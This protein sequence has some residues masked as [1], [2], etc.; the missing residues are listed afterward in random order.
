MSDPQN[1]LIIRLS[2]LGDIILASPLIRILRSKYPAAQIDLLVKPQYAEV[3]RSNPHLS[4]II[5]LSG[6]LAPLGARL[7]A[8]RYDLLID[9]HNSLRSRY[10]RWRAHPRAVR[11]VNKYALRRFLLVHFKWNLYRGVIPVAERYLAAGGNLLNDGLGLEVFLPDQV[12]AAV[13][14]RLSSTRLET[15]DRVI[16]F[17]PTARH[18]TKRWP[19]ERFVELGVQLARARKVKIL[20]FGGRDEADYCGDIAQMINA[21]LGSAVAES[22]AGKFSLL[23]TAAAFDRCHLVVSNDTGLMHLAAARRRKVVAIFG[24]SV[25]EFGFLPYGTE[26]T[27]LEAA[28]VACRPCSHVGRATCPKGHFRCMKEIQ[29]AEV[30]AAAEQLLGRG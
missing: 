6:D 18:F 1:I 13:S 20:L 22:V 5:E 17:A 8:S 7:C 26:H 19:P 24:S 11:V 12:G 4:T 16:G 25:R 3:M 14:A 28:G 29:V 15:A 2:S 9:I 27:L 21:S 23:E 30:A 10:L